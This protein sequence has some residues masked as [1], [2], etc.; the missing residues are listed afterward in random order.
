MSSTPCAISSPSAD[1]GIAVVGLGCRYPGAA[2]IRALWENI[3]ARRQAFRR[4]PDC[5]LPLGHYQDPDRSH[6]DKIYSTRAAVLEDFAFDWAARRIPKS[7]YDVTDIAHW[8]ALEVA[9]QAVT[10]A[11]YDADRLPKDRCGVIL[12]NSLTGEQWRATIMRLRWPFIARV[13]REAA[14][15]E[16]RSPEDTARLLAIAEPCF[17]SVF[18]EFNEDALAGSL[19]NTIAGRI[20]NYLDLHGGGYTVDGAC[21]SSLLAVITAARSLLCG[22]IDLALAGGVDVSLDTFELIGFARTGALTAGNANIYDRRASGFLPGEGC[23]MVVLKRLDDARRDGDYVYAVLRGWGVSSDGKGGITAPTVEGQALALRA[24]YRQAGYAAASLDFI[25]GHGTGTPLGDKVE[26]SGIGL[27]MDDSPQEACQAL[28]EQRGCGVTS[29]KSIV[30]H[31]KAAAGIGGFIKA[32]LGVHRRVV[33]PTA[34]C[35][36]P[37]PLFQDRA[38]R[39]YPVV[40]GERRDTSATLRAGISAMGFGGI[41]THVTIESGDRCDGRWT[42]TLDERALL[43]HGQHSELVLAS[44]ASVAEL[45][46]RMAEIRTLAEGLSVA[47]LADFSAHALAQADLDLPCR[48]AFV[49]EDPEQLVDWTARIEEPLSGRATHDGGSWSSPCQR[50]WLGTLRRDATQ[51]LGMLFPGQGVQALGAARRLVDRFGWARELVEQADQWLLGIGARPV[52]PLLFRDTERAR[53][54]ATVAAWKAELARTELAQPA[55]V[56]ASLLW[57]RY[58]ESLAIRPSIVAGH[59]LGELTALHAAGVLDARAVIT[60]AAQRGQAMAD[61][62]AASGYVGGMAFVRCAKDAALSLC[63][64]LGHGLVVANHNSPLQVVIA[65]PLEAIT[66]VVTEAQAQG[67]QAQELSVSAAFHSPQMAAAVAVLQRSEI[68]TSG[69]GAATLPVLSSMTGA[70]I[71]PGID[72]RGHL[73]AQI[74]APVEF[75]TAVQRLPQ[76]AEVLLEVGPGRVL[77]GL[78]HDGLGAAAPLL[79]PVESRPELDVDLNVALA[80]L[81]AR[82][83]RWQPARLHQ[84]R[85]IRA[86]VPASRRQF[87]DNPCERPIRTEEAIAAAGIAPQAAGPRPLGDLLAHVAA[88]PEVLKRYWARRGGLVSRLFERFIE[89]DLQDADAGDDLTA[90]AA[91]LAGT[92]A[93]RELPLPSSPATETR[94][95]AA[96]AAG[97]S[98]PANDDAATVLLELVAKRT[99]FP[100]ASLRMHFRMLDDL[101]LDSIKAAEIVAKAGSRLA[102]V[103]GSIDAAGFANATLQEIAEALRREAPSKPSSPAAA[104]ADS[105]SDR[106]RAAAPPLQSRRYPAFTRSFAV[107]WH[108]E[109]IAPSPRPHA[110]DAQASARTEWANARVLLLADASAQRDELAQL[111]RT[112][113]A[114][115]SVVPFAKVA[116]APASQF[117][118]YVVL[119]SAGAAASDGID[120]EHL[121]TQLCAASRLLPDD[122]MTGVSPNTSTLATAPTVSWLQYGFA[123]DDGTPRSVGSVDAFLASVHHE[124]PAI[125]FRSLSCP[126]GLPLAQIVEALGHERALPQRFVRA[127]YSAAGVREV[128][129]PRLLEPANDTPRAA[130]L[131]P[132]DVILVTGGAKGITAE[133][134]LALGRQ[135]RAKLILVGSSPAASLGTALERFREAEVPVDYQQCDLTQLEQVRALIGHVEQAHGP[136]TAVVHGAG[137]N[138]PA[139]IRHPV[140]AEALAEIGPKLLGAAHLFQA[141][142]R[143]PPRVFVALTSVIGVTG[144]RGNAWYAF[145]NECL[146]RQLGHFAARHPQTAPLSL[147]FSAWQEVGMAAR[148]GRLEALATAGVDTI[149]LAEGVRRFLHLVSH[150]PSARQV[151]V[152]GRLGAL[153]TWT[154]APPPIPPNWRFVEQLA[155]FTPGVEAVS[156]VHLSLQKDAYLADHCLDGSY[157]FPTVFGLEAMAQLVALVTG[158]SALRPLQLENIV[159]ER[160]IVVDPEEGLDVEIW[161]LALEAASAGGPTRVEAG[162]R[163]SQ[164]GWAVDHF[165]ARFV[166]E[167]PPPLAAILQLPPSTTSIRPEQELYGALLFQGPRFHRLREV[168]HV[169]ETSCAFTGHCDDTGEWILGDPYFRDALLQS[170]QLCVTPHFCLPV[171]IAGLRIFSSSAAAGPCLRPAV[172]RIEEVR[173]DGFVATVSVLD[174][175]GGVYEELS[176]YRSRTIRREPTLP[177]P[178]ELRFCHQSSLELLRATVLPRVARLGLEVPTLGLQHLPGLHQQ[179]PATRHALERPLLSATCRAAA[180]RTGSPALDPA[181]QWDAAGRPTVLGDSGLHVSLAHDDAYCL[182]AAARQPVGCDL[183]PITTQRSDEEWRTLLG[184]RGA[185]AFSELVKRWQAAHSSGSICGASVVDSAG[186]LLWSCLEAIRKASLAPW[187]TDAPPL[188]MIEAG[189]EDVTVEAPD[190]KLRALASLVRLGPAHQHALAVVLFPGGGTSAS[191]VRARRARR[192]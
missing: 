101:H 28:S 168:H 146:D 16:G 73:A 56:L 2:D 86:F 69:L 152:T 117:T 3:L 151:V 138:R 157:L 92:P 20:C 159:L 75:A 107:E 136:I 55:I 19:S 46:T 158:R 132:K 190:T 160:P 65:G 135:T 70:V 5:R 1:L 66:R 96:T 8:L 7:T 164:T 44:A 172:T 60:L 141:L 179:P 192:P 153:D 183:E 63:Q 36:E 90:P 178:A 106:P 147:A 84:Q 150:D 98:S 57:L 143:Q 125:S 35:L 134:A 163:T 13:L 165:A 104:A 148:L 175:K 116:E 10:D 111:L 182:C 51:R 171:R 6:V 185:A 187:N 37:H 45:R 142:D 89:V 15:I 85:L 103:P 100:E 108:A 26:L 127:R 170:A 93:K 88:D 97:S 9:L 38:R 17:K 61:A 31:T 49:V 181:V 139:L 176:G 109:A 156:R 25:E 186:T 131:G 113:G 112:R 129:H 58:L 177:T 121:V 149:A 167:A 4:L 161:A 72:L 54:S 47:E 41:N 12:G 114:E 18:H 118:D 137:L 95:E 30:G 115:V 80:G 34:G 110:A 122:P 74:T 50:A 189:A 33:P 120:I 59:S 24:A 42:P 169:D 83:I 180:R 64:R 53:D 162:I 130:Q 145:A 94:R 174:P 68:L 102:L 184:R 119:F 14:G 71:E 21:S 188:T 48:A 22:E 133:C 32:V 128:P 43:A 81:F 140:A 166:L 99:G 29:F 76:H 77:C 11:G 78:V 40:H 105:F 67:L 154:P 91:L 27:V 123:A 39:I 87:I 124:R 79:L 82:G 155:A 62:A 173:D 52:G 191:A 126:R 144:M 23:G